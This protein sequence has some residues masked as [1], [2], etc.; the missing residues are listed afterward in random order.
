MVA[1]VVVGVVVGGHH[2]MDFECPVDYVGIYCKRHRYQ[3]LPR[4]NASV[5]PING[6]EPVG[7]LGLFVVGL[8][9][10]HRALSYMAFGN[11]CRRASTGLEV[12][13]VYQFL[14]VNRV[15]YILYSKGQLRRT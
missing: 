4:I 6:I 2:L 15:F 7:D 10:S 13:L 12:V 5:V 8:H 1:G 11:F 3:Y 14:S 9:G